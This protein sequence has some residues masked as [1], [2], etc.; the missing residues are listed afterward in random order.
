M[1]ANDLSPLIRNPIVLYSFLAVYGVMMLVL[2]AYVHTKFRRASKTLKLLQ[3]EW[4]SAESQHA[5]IVGV[6][7]EHLSKLST[8]AKSSAPVT[9]AAGGIGP[10]VRSQILALAKRGTRAIDIARSCGLQEGEV[11][12][13]LG[14]SRLQR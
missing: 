9:R 12:V 3:V 8:V 7:Q 14:M 11:D 13:I 6:A 5:N 1:P 2:A 10:D 4:Q